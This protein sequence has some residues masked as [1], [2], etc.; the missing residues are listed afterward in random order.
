MYDKYVYLTVDNLPIGFEEYLNF[1]YYHIWY[2]EQSL[3]DFLK[4]RQEEEKK[5][6]GKYDP[7]MNTNSMFSS[8]MASVK[9]L[10]S[11]IGHSMP[12]MP[13]IPNMKF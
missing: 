3:Q 6:Q 2:L 7:G 4:A 5:Q 1:P 11:K 9:S 10:Q 8:Q 13:K 12:S